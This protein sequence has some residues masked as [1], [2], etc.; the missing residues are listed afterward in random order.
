MTSLLDKLSSYNIFN[1]LLPG[2]LFAF[3]LEKTTDYSILHANI[4]IS[5]FV[6]Y[7]AG[8]VISR[9]GSLILEPLL[10]KIS[11][12]RFVGYDEFVVASKADPKIELLSETNNMYRTLCALFVLTLV[13]DGYSVIE[14]K[15]P[16]L[17]EWTPYIVVVLLLVM[18]LFSYRKQTAYVESRVNL[19]GEGSSQRQ[20]SGAVEKEP[21]Q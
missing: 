8:L 15:W 12:V 18:F 10:K 16:V 14:Q 13:V 21:N 2:V 19:K 1:Y 9:F 11:F 17:G 5:A 20:D 4:A 3:L 6:V 7:F